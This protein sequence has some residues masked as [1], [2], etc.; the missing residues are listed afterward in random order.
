MTTSLGGRAFIQSILMRSDLMEPVLGGY[1]GP[2]VF[3]G[4]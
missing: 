4:L 3:G 1:R 2:R